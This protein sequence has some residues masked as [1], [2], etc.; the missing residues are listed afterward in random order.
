M[1]R[2]TDT[3]HTIVIGSGSGGLTV[4]VGLSK[5]G[6]RVA[7]VEAN[8]VGGDCTNVGCVPSKTLIHLVTHPGDRSPAEILARVQEK[9]NHLRIEETAWVKGM[10]NLTFLEGRARFV[11]LERLEVALTDGGTQTLSAPNIVIATGAKPAV[12]PID[13][14][15]ATRTLTNESLFELAHKPEHLVIV[16]GGVVGSE[17]AFA[18][19][20]LGSRVSLISRS[21]RVLSASEP[22]ASAVVGEAMTAQGIDLYLNAQ[23]GAYDEATQT[24]YVQRGGER[25]ALSGVDKVLLA[26]GRVPNTDGL[27]IETT[28]VTF[29]D[30]G[31]PTDAYGVTDVKGIY[32]IGDVNPA[33]S[34]THSANAQGRRLVRRLAFP[35]L[36]AWGQEPPYP[37]ATFTDPEVAAIGPSLAELTERLH[38]ALIRTVRFELPKTDKGYTEGLER[39]FILIHAVRLTGRVLGATIVAPR[40]SEMISLLTAAVYHGLSLYKLSSLVFPYPVLS[41]G[42]KK[43]A[44]AFVFETL[45]NLPREGSSYLR[46]RWAGP[47][48]P[49]K[50]AERRPHRGERQPTN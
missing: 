46:Y 15:P 14:L 8:D 32:A 25:V 19:R 38:P 9:R 42:I 5:L 22:E 16:G 40:A 27:G 35:Y 37:N 6:K 45:P 29:G 26:V 33:S 30:K 31:I 7:L 34:Y 24:M 1:N 50:T 47:P 18:F 39:G 20:K 4:A 41:E 17:M 2:R 48:T 44:D 3:F 10:D 36:P 13:G 23:P 28:G 21:G 12:I 11:S 43:A 49:D